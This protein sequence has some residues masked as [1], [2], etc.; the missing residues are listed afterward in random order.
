MAVVVDVD[1]GAGRAMHQMR[2]QP[3]A[4][5]MHVASSEVVWIENGIE[6]GICR[7]RKFNR[8]TSHSRN[9]LQ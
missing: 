9:G 5:Q 2:W 4:E 7:N 3:R 6:E 8:D 1:V